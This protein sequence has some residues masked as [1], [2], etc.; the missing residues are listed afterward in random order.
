MHKIAENLTL[1]H[2]A[3]NQAA[4]AAHRAP[5]EI[6]LLAVSKTRPT[7]DIAE[8]FAAGQA[9]F[10]EN[11][12]QEALVKIQALKSLPLVWH[13]IGPIQSN[14]TRLI[15]EHFHWVHSVSSLK[16]AQRLS[17]QRPPELPPLQICLQV[18]IDEEPNKSGCTP[19]HTVKL[20]NAIFS[21]PQ[22]ELRGLMAIPKLNNSLT[23]FTELANLKRRIKGT[24]G[25]P[26]DTLSM[27]MSGDLSE[28]VA[29]GATIVRIGTA[30]FGERE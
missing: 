21:L 25:I 30:I 16:I 9:D 6:R 10:G 14:K 18:N 3:I 29:C 13:F 11:Y 12:A 5:S 23:A 17:D 15:A 4:L 8:A 7:E 24:T 27:G 28:A 26:L 20:A 19:A 22:L 2:N 1:V